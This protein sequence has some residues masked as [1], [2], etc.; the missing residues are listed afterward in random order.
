MKP[1]CSA[2]AACLAALS[3]LVS[4][5][6]TAPGNGLEPENV[7][8]IRAQAEQ[9]SP[10]AMYYLGLHYE[11]EN[12]MTEAAKWFLAAARKDDLD[13][14]YKLAQCY[15]KGTGVPQ[16][17]QESFQWYRKAG[18]NGILEAQFPLGVHYEKGNGVKQ[19]KS[20]AASWYRM[21]AEQR[22]AKAQYSFAVCCEKRLR[23]HQKPGGRHLLV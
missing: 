9:G 10:E 8:S 11:Q 22:D 5:A 2:F 13:A 3:F 18:E 15:E 6:D 23:R 19:S 20:D 7:A 1:C 16:D 4:A 17:D 14:Q 12:D 21:A